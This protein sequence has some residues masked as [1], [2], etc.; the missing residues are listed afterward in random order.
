[1][2]YVYVY[3]EWDILKEN[4]KDSEHKVEKHVSV[5][6]TRPSFSFLLQQGRIR[7]RMTTIDVANKLNISPKSVSLYENGTE[8]PNDEVAALLRDLLDI[9]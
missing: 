1:M 4:N 2:T 7:K 6:N 8:S 9:S 5:N 3:H